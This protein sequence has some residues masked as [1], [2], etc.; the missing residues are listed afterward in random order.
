AVLAVF[1]Q[2]AAAAPEENANI[3]VMSKMAVALHELSKSSPTSTDLTGDLE[4][5]AKTPADRL[6]LA[7]VYAATQ[8]P[9]KALQRLD[10]VEQE[11]ATLH[12]DVQTARTLCQGGDVPAETWHTFHEK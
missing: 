3:R 5:T 10:A 4:K 12:D 8:G 7:I 1:E 11:D 6:R 2:K 9:E